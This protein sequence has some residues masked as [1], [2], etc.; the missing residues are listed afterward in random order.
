M[1]TEKMINKQFLLSFLV[2]S[3]SSVYAREVNDSTIIDE[4]RSIIY[5]ENGTSIILSSQIKP[6][7]DGSSRSLRD[8]VLDELMILDAKRFNF[9]VTDDDIERY[10]SELQ[11]VN[12]ITR[13]G[14]ERVMQDMGYTYE[15]GKEQMRRRQII[16]QIIDARVKSDKRFLVQREDVEKFDE[17]H[18][19]YEDARFQ[20]QQVVIP[21]KLAL[22]KTF[23][24]SELDELDWEDPFEVT[25]SELADDKQFIV[26]API[27]TLIDRERVSEGV[28]LTRLISKIEK[29]RIPLDDR[30]EKISNQI[31]MKR[32]KDL[33]QEYSD[34][35]LEN[36]A[37]R[38]IHE[39]DR[40]DV[41]AN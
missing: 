30:Y 13:A 10:I 2:L 15:E 25:Q 6:T 12:G 7:L 28:E 32:Y 29:K 35:L 16:D 19:L 31:M 39:E 9:S 40:A 37:I 33:M 23:T 5:D 38:F 22:E 21:E 1:K 34:Q 36:A 11:R 4:I 20:L 17:E 27:G 3:L 14:L 26:D 8:I 24:Q 41:L 18:P